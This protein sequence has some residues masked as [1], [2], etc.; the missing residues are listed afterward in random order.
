VG[1][2]S[3][4]TDPKTGK[5]ADVDAKEGE[6]QGLIVST[7]P[8]KIFENKIK[9][10]SNVDYGINMNIGV[11]VGGTPEEVHDGTDNVYW[12]ASSINGGKFTFDS[13]DQA[14]S[15]SKSIKTD[16]ADDN[17]VMQ[18]DKGS[19]LDLTN[20]TSLTIWIY[21][22]KDWKAGDQI[23]IFGWNTAAGTMIGNAVSLEDYFN[24]D[25]F[26]VWQSFSIPLA[27]M[28]LTG[29][30]IDALRIQ[31]IASEG[32]SP[33]FYLDDIQIEETP[34]SGSSIS[35]FI[36]EP[37]LQT[38]LHIQ[39]I[40][41]FMADNDFDSTVADATAPHLPYNSILGVSPSNGIVY[42]R[43]QDGETK[44]S[45]SIRQIGD[46]MQ[47]PGV[48][49]VGFGSAG[50]TNTWLTLKMT[51]TEPLILKSENS[52]KLQLIVSDDLSG[53]DVF[54]G[55]VGAKEETRPL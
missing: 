20:Y 3:F 35:T 18:L 47:L 37:D 42:Q 12:T 4:I 27:D 2:K 55:S 50:A 11:T 48:E 43:I 8:L 38:W 52:D 45:A 23:D 39:D 13:A 21:V 28:S 1:I 33:K 29:Q 53:L 5:N 30:T 36:V 26:D 10:F 9:F 24:Y 34:S 44:F 32:K 19:N 16:N 25:D 41:I 46:L 6:S 15:G 51:P 40:N 14:H 31:I 54:R 7:Q 22:D 49:I 17:D